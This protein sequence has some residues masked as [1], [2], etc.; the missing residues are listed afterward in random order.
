M[1]GYPGS[2][3]KPHVVIEDVTDADEKADKASGT[4]GVIR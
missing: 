2:R 4:T 3:K 1:F